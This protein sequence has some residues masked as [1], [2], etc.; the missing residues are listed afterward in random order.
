MGK[1]ESKFVK[2]MSILD[3]FEV[4]GTLLGI[5]VL[6]HFIQKSK[7]KSQFKNSFTITLFDLIILKNPILK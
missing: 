2:D 3:A 4:K 1:G 7:K 6:I 5:L